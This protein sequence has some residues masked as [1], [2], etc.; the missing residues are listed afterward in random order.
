MRVLHN[1]E[2]PRHLWCEFV[3]GNSFA[4]PFQTS[5]YYDFFNS[6][7]NLTADAIAIEDNKKLIA[8]I[9]ISFQKEKGIKGFFSKRAIIYGGPLIEKGSDTALIR[10]FHELKKELKNKVIYAEFR[11]LHNY[12]EYKSLFEQE[13]WEYKPYLNFRVP[14]SEET[15]VWSNLNR[16][17]KRQIKKALSNGVISREA[18]STSEVE[19][20][21][22]ILYTIYKNK[23]KKPIYDW[24]FFKHLYQSDFCKVFVV[25]AGNRIIGGHFCLINKNVI[26]DWYGCGLDKAYK[27]LAP[28]TMAVYTILQYGTKNNFKYFDF[29]G[30]GSPDENYGVREFKAQFGGELVE[31]GRFKL[32]LNPAM[33]RIG[34]LG[35]L[36]LSKFKK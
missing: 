34:E 19:E 27:D 11:N 29:M 5:E 8:L 2:I 28:S 16:L 4:T 25:K 26:F 9:V 35:M 12:S 10:L 1:Q 6:V 22:K 33:Y 3:A 18:E 17:R 23:I 21:Y 20:L 14:C 15:S 30:A 36:F 7:Q 24:I 13:G 31:Y 32:I